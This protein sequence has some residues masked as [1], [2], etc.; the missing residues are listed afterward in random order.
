MIWA[1]AVVVVLLGLVAVLNG[2]F[3]GMLG[4][5]D[6]QISLTY[7]LLLLALLGSS[8]AIGYRGRLNSALKHG[9]TQQK[10]RV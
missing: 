6:H 3:P 4:N 1:I 7:N 10:E 2:I 9:A 5:E 8:V